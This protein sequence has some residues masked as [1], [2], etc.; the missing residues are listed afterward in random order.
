[1]SLADFEAA[2]AKFC[3]RP[4]DAVRR[5]LERRGGS[6]GGGG[7]SYALRACFAA[8]HALT[9]LRDGLKLGGSGS[10]SGGGGGGGGGGNGAVILSNEVATPRGGKFSASWALGAL[11]AEVLGV[12]SVGGG[13]SG[14]GSGGSGADG[15]GAVRSLSAG[16]QRGAAAARGAGGGLLAAP[17]TD[18]GAVAL[19]AAFCLGCI[20]AMAALSRARV[21]VV[22]AGGAAGGAAALEKG[23][24]GAT[25][26]GELE[27]L[28]GGGG[29]GGSGG[30]GGGVERPPS[31]L[32]IT[33][34][35]GRVSPGPG[36]AGG[37]LPESRS[38]G[39]MAGGA[40]ARGVEAARR[41]A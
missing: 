11:L 41:R 35:T 4:W 36:I 30:S 15:G 6:A 32:A 7:D 24:S 12:G 9:L 39:A 17:R 8:A 38:R 33:V 27:L 26:A 23:R 5:E 40:A 1:M 20:F 10:G 29:G 37:A 18:G 13:G 19:A 2:A 22:G 16:L 34:A 28:L 31:S 25:S 21:G 14:A 3:S